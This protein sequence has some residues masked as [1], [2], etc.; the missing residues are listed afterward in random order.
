[1]A[2]NKSLG[3]HFTQG[4]ALSRHSIWQMFIVY[5]IIDFDYALTDH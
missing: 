4:K 2:I 5:C 3:Y 1:M